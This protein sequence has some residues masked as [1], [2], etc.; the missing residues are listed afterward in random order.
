MTLSSTPLRYELVSNAAGL[1][2]ILDHQLEAWAHLLPAEYTWGTLPEIFATTNYDYLF[3]DDYE[4]GYE[5]S[6]EYY[7]P[8]SYD[9]YIST[10]TNFPHITRL[11]Y[12]ASREQFISDHPELF[13]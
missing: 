12:F 2:G 9:T 11:G 10:F 13:I 1:Y 7:P 6:T 8:Y 5:D 4:E 3:V